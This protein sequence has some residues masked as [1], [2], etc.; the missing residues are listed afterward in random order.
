LTISISGLFAYRLLVQA[1]IARRDAEQA[2]EA[3]AEM[4]ER[5][6]WLEEQL[7]RQEEQLFAFELWE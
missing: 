7:Q 3:E 6:E 1:Q 2:A 5:V 4:N